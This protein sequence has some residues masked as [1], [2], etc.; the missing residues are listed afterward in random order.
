MNHLP[1][2]A[3]RHK[4]QLAVSMNT[5]EPHHAMIVVITAALLC[6]GLIV[7]LRPMLQRDALA[8]P[9]ARSSRVVPT[10]QGAGIAVITA[11]LQVAVVCAIAMNIVIPEMLFGA[12]LF[13]A[14]VGLADVIKPIQVLPRLLLRLFCLRPP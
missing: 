12:T 11:T 4:Y 8:R 1:S 14:V 13:L 3:C 5:F 9:N 2:R 7:L 10:P 6:A